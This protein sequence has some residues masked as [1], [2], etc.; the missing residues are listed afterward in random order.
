MKRRLTDTWRAHL[1]L[2]R[3]SLIVL[4]LVSGISWML[5]VAQARDG[6]ARTLDPSDW[7]WAEASTYDE[8]AAPS[9]GWQPNRPNEKMPATNIWL[10]VPLP[11]GDP[12][13]PYLQVKG[14]GSLRAF[15]GNN[16][17]YSYLLNKKEW[18]VPV[19]QW[20][21]VQLPLPQPPYIDLLVRLGNESVLRL[22][23]AYGD[24]SGL[25][26]SMLREDLDNL[27][28]G[29]LLIFSGCIALGLYKSQRNQLYLYFSLL[30]VSGGYAALVQNDLQQAIIDVPALVYFQNVCLPIATFAFIGAMEQVFSGINARAIRLFRHTALTL[31]AFSII[32]ALTSITLYMWSILVFTPIFIVIFIAAYWTIL[33]AY[34]QRRDLESIWI[35]AGFSSLA[36][37]TL[38]HIYRFII[39][40]RVPEQVQETTAWV[41]QLPKDLLFLGLFA[42]I[43]CLIRVIMY[44]YMAMNRQLTEFNRS[45]EQI[46]QTRT[47][48]LQE[49]TEQLQRANERL[50]ASMRENAEAIAESMIMEERHRI[51]GSIHDT[52]GHTLSDTVVHMEEANKLIYADRG[53]AEEKLAASQEL[54]RRGLEDIRQSVRLLREDA[55]HYDLPGAIGAL[56]RETEQATGCHFERQLGPLPSQLSTLQKRLLFQTLQEGI[57]TGLKS[58]KPAR[59]FRLSV[60][61]DQRDETVRLKLADDG[62]LTRADDW[63]IGMRALAEQADRLGG[64]L[65]A[66]ATEEGNRLSLTIPASP[67]GASSWMI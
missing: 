39:Y 62:R 30:A 14:I 28:I 17:I 11:Q 13:D 19:G 57:A 49:R 21:M 46:V 40:D 51:T 53:H 7:Q 12:K 67:G 1:P 38:I 34:R 23:A 65:T 60:S 48:E 32:G 31:S 50:A 59:R 42:F 41:L 37:I 15:D 44:R 9:S 3:T 24:K 52:V 20:K 2:L 47:Y 26:G 10:R 63:G 35:M 66:E 64:L 45:L 16:R 33:V 61:F 54:L 55:G 29:V 25:V 36:A 18:I 8:V 5:A 56:I 43:V 4:V 27:L 6:S 58:K 22:E